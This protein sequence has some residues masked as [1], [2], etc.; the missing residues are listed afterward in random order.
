MRILTQQ[1]PNLALIEAAFPGRPAG[2]I[3]AYGQTIYNPDG[4]NVIPMLVEHETVHSVRQERLGVDQW[5]ARYCEDAPWRYREELYAHVRE[6]QVALQLASVKLV[7][8][9]GSPRL[10]RVQLRAAERKLILARS[11]RRLV[12]PLY[13]YGPE[14][15]FERAKRDIMELSVCGD[16]TML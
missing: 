16:V 3:Y 9:Q 8:G 14:R 2:V 4:I 13:G 10:E 1:P 11:A 15:H 6:Y 7:K 5:W 12:A